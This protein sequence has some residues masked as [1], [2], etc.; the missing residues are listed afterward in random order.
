MDFSCVTSN[1]GLLSST[2]ISA[3]SSFFFVTLLSAS[4][5]RLAG[6]S[7]TRTST[8]R[9]RAAINSFM[10]E[11]SEKRNIFTR[12]D[13]RAPAIAL[14]RGF[15]VSSG[16]TIKLCVTSNPSVLEFLLLRGCL[17]ALA[18]RFFFELYTIQFRVRSTTR[19]Q[20]LVRS[21]LEDHAV[22]QYQY[23]VS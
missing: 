23:V 22:F 11:G 8:P 9:F 6:F 14:S 3:A 18:H 13:F 21:L 1:A 16:S 15:A 20:L 19:Q 5:L 4:P 7:M 2:S 12:N 10:R 17:T